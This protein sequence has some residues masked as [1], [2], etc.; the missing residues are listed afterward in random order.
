MQ[1]QKR[2]IFSA[3]LGNWS[4]FRGKGKK[5]R[6]Q[7]GEEKAFLCQKKEKTVP[8]GFCVGGK[9]GKGFQKKKPAGRRGE[10]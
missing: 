9:G 5:K 2:G 10:T 6:N 3:K 4:Y 8:G 1:G 7:E